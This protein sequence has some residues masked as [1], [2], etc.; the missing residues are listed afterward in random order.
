[1]RS[2]LSIICT[3]ITL[4]AVSHLTAGDA[5]DRIKP[6][7]QVWTGTDHFDDKDLFMSMI[8]QLQLDQTHGVLYV[9]AWQ[10]K[11]QRA[12]TPAGCP[13]LAYH[14]RT[15]VRGRLS[16]I[17]NRVSF[18]GQSADEVVLYPKGTIGKG[19]CVDNL[20]GVILERLMKAI[21]TDSCHP[22]T[23]MVLERRNCV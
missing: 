5:A 4:T 14:S 15:T 11:G 1:M 10:C 13:R 20:D 18:I 8:L 3:L 21:H 17:S 7:P 12:A 9:E 19:Y 16:V 2:V 6:C 23:H 22:T